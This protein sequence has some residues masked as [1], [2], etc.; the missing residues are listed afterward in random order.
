MYEN[1]LVFTTMEYA[2][3]FVKIRHDALLEAMSDEFGAKLKVN[4]NMDSAT[5]HVHFDMFLHV[6]DIDN[7]LEADEKHGDVLGRFGLMM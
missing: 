5:E 2:H 6:K 7:T 1:R 4:S 3:H